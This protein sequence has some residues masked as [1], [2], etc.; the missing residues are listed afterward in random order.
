M[1][2]IQT[3]DNG[4]NNLDDFSVVFFFFNL[5]FLLYEKKAILYTINGLELFY[6]S[7]FV[8]AII[9]TVFLVFLNYENPLFYSQSKRKLIL[10]FQIFMS[11]A[12]FIATTVNLLNRKLTDD[13]VICKNYSIQKINYEGGS[14]RSRSDPTIDLKLEHNQN[15]TFEIETD[16]YLQLLGTGKVKLCKSKGIFGYDYVT[17]FESK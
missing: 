16:L 7:L 11:I 9:A 15:Q 8:G 17:K 10:N 2:N 12:F 4:L 14:G 6:R 13:I 1:K 3:K 5:L